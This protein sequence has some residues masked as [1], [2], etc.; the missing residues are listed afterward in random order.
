MNV[1]FAPAFAMLEKFVPVAQFAIVM[2]VFILV[3]DIIYS[4]EP[5]SIFLVEFFGAPFT[6][7]FGGA[8]V[9]VSGLWFS[10][11]HKS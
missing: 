4:L 7:Q 2:V 10:K 5:A 11:A 8:I 3:S 6:F 1:F 9:L